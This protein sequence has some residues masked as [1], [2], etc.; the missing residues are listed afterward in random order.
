M[1]TSKTVLAGPTPGR[2]ERFTLVACQPTRRL[3]H[4]LS[5]AAFKK[6]LFLTSDLVTV[7]L[8]HRLAELLVV[9][10]LDVSL[11]FAN[12]SH[13]YLFYIPFFAIVLHLSGGYSH[14]D[15]R[16]PEKE[17][18]LGFKG[19]SIFFVCLVCANF[20]LF[21][22]EGFSRYLLFLWYVFSLWFVLGAR[23]S[24]RGAYTGL[25]RRGL[26]RETTLLVGPTERLTQFQSE[27]SIQRYLRHD[28]IGLLVTGAMVEFKNGR[29]DDISL[30]GNLDDWEEIAER[31]RVQWMLFSVP[32]EEFCQSARVI[33]IMRA[34]QEKGI[35]VGIYSGLFGLSEFEFERDQF[36]GFFRVNSHHP[37]SRLV[38]LTMKSAID[39]IFGLVGSLI[40]LLL[41][42]IIGLLLKIED[43]GPVF[44][45]SE[46]VA[47]DGSI[48]YYRK[49]RTMVRN[50][51]EIL[52]NTPHLKKQFDQN[53]KLKDDPRV[54]RFGRFLRKYSIDEF[55]QFFSL[56]TGKLTFVGPRTIR[57]EEAC[58]YAD[59]LPRLLSVKPGMTGYWQVMGRQTTTYKERVRMDM[60]YIDHWSLWLDLV[61]IA[62]TFWKVLRAD[63]AY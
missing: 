40:A 31:F 43:G 47:G 57:Q 63:G 1:V 25:W 29:S 20:V 51:D 37:W 28:V 12:P 58:R 21:K 24:I 8:A 53:Y 61:I 33:E 55:P 44:Y 45:H 60:F 7:G 9:H 41:T 59:C 19:V 46:F 34:C 56:L 3:W 18:E 49:F 54:L 35:E 4:T 50:A 36:S 17:L 62:K 10:W 23:F 42:P 38:Q 52:E 22:T 6:L 15:L 11:A 48:R 30:V 39:R 14:P 16:R 32:G 26:A 27:L 5:G 2:A 13:Y